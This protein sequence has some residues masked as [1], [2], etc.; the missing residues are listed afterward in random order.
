MATGGCVQL[1]ALRACDVIRA[2]MA[3]KVILLESALSRNYIHWIIAQ[4]LRRAMCSYSLLFV[5]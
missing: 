1:F 3:E 2:K 5:L 4:R